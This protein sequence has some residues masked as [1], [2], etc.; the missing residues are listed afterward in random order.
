MCSSDQVN[1]LAGTAVDVSGANIGALYKCTYKFEVA[2]DAG[3]PSFKVKEST[4]VKFNLHW[5][6]FE[7]AQL[8]SSVA[9]TSANPWNLGDVTGKWPMPIKKYMSAGSND[10]SDSNVKL[11]D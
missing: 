4:F 11:T 3:A 8:T 1:A 7:N 6:E 10:G 5:L 2:A 9:E